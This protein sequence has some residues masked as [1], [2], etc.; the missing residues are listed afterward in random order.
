MLHL[1][2]DWSEASYLTVCARRR[3]RA[4]GGCAEAVPPM[5]A[6]GEAKVFWTFPL[7]SPGLQNPER[8]EPSPGD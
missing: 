2:K 4:L 3:H 8:N 5:A 1:H 6:E 7:A